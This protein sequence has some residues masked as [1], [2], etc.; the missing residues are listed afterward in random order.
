MNRILAGADYTFDIVL[1]DATG[2]PFELAGSTV[3]FEARTPGGVVALTQTLVVNGFG[4]A[5]T[6]DGLEIGAGGHTSGEITQT[7]TAAETSDLPAGLL[8]WR[9]TLLD[10]TGAT[11]YPLQGKWTSEHATYL[12]AHLSRRAL[13]KRIADRL[14]DLVVLEATSAS[15]SPTTFIDVLNISGAADSLIGRQMV[16]TSGAN[17]GH[18]ARIH[19]SNESTSTI[20]FAPAATTTFA[21]GDVIEVYNERSRGWTVAEYNRAINDAISDTW[22][23][24]AATF[25]A[26]F[27]ATFTT[28]TPTITV[29]SVMDEV[30]EVARKD[31][32]DN[33]WV[34][35]VRDRFN[36]WEVDGPTGVITLRGPR[37]SMA[38]GALI[39]LAGYGPHP[40]LN[41]DSD[42]TALHPE[43][44]TAECA[45]RLAVSGL[46]RDQN[47]GNI[48]LLLQ[49]EREAMR[50]RIRTLREPHTVRVRG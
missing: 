8:T 35:I 32:Y 23:L 21:A 29:P 5:T 37:A 40:T 22:P 26:E 10:S 41:D 30:Y 36:G 14:G 1:T 7:L 42:E 33:T 27:A 9:F 28:A 25:T 34:P 48:V 17:I 45:Y 16:V 3:T 4:V 19:N 20:T 44:L 24:S 2:G 12:D 43:W 47:R 15:L 38:E 13:R 31:S 6:S 49:R 18:V 11:S 50:S 46:D 39:R